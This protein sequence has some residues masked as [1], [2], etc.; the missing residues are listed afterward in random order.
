MFTHSRNSCQRK[1]SWGWMRPCRCPYYLFLL[2]D[3]LR[4]NM[5][6]LATL[7]L[8]CQEKLCRTFVA[9]LEKCVDVTEFLMQS[10]ST[11]FCNDRYR[12]SF[13]FGV[14]FLFF[15][16]HTKPGLLKLCIN[17]HKW[18]KTLISFP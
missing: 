15:F 14:R 7:K 13:L 2:L 12:N 8:Q 18:L 11:F 16:S 5:C 10:K 1:V 3:V 17:M 4:F 6:I 9:Q